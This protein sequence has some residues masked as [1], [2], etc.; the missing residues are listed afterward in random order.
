MFRYL[1]CV[2][3]LNTSI[4]NIGLLEAPIEVIS[5]SSDKEGR[6]FDHKTNLIH[7]SYANNDEFELIKNQSKLTTILPK[8]Q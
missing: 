4:L 5:I 2:L 3:C 7:N 8:V 6:L 1:C